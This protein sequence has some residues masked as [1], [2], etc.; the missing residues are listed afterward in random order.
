MVPPTTSSAVDLGGLHPARV[1][2]LGLNVPVVEHV[3][4]HF[5]GTSLADS[6]L[7]WKC[8]DSVRKVGS[9][10]VGDGFGRDPTKVFIVQ[11]AVPDLRS[12]HDDLVAA[13]TG[14]E[15]PLR[16]VDISKLSEEKGSRRFLRVI[17][18]LAPESDVVGE[19]VGGG[20]IFEEMPA[21]AR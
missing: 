10:D 21:L 2:A 17:A 5:R 4:N 18:F 13:R 8:V 1:V 15:G 16:V 3:R 12:G 19:W 11:N 14:E 7:S 20:P 6:L 9:E